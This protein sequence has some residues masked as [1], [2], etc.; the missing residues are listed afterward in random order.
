MPAIV[1]RRTCF[2]AP[3]A[4]VDARRLGVAA[5]LQVRR[6]EEAVHPRGVLLQV[7]P[8]PRQPVD[9]LDE[10]EAGEVGGE[11]VQLVPVWLRHVVG[12]GAQGGGG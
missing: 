10:V 5:A 7:Q 4:L 1:H 9:Q 11:L 12:G 2:E 3:Q 6:L 8:V